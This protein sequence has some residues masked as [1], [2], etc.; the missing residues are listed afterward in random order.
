MSDDNFE[1]SWY[2]PPPSIWVRKEGDKIS[3][4]LEVMSIYWVLRK[5][6][7]KWV[8]RGSKLLSKL[9]TSGYLANLTIEFEEM[10]SNIS[11]LRILTTKSTGVMGWTALSINNIPCRRHSGPPGWG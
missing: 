5:E 9:R 3:V 8:G 10:L 6:G 1:Y 11:D 2:A 4:R 7:D